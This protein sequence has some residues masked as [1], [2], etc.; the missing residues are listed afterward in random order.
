V[1]APTTLSELGIKQNELSQI[2]EITLTAPISK[3]NPKKYTKDELIKMFNK[4]Y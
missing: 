3:L 2:A 4:I 1:K